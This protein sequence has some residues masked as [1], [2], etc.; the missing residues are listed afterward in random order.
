MTAHLHF[1]RP[2]FTRHPGPGSSRSRRR[3]ALVDFFN[4][5]V[6]VRSGS[7]D[8]YGELCARWWPCTDRRRIE[9][10]RATVAFAVFLLAPAFGLQLGRRSL[11][12]AAAAKV[13]PAP[14]PAAALPALDSAAAAALAPN[15]AAAAP[16]S[17]VDLPNGCQYSVVE[18]GTG[19]P[20]RAGETVAVRLRGLL[21]DGSTFYET[22]NSPLLFKIG[23]AVGAVRADG[24]V[25]PA[26]DVAVSRMRG[27]ERGRLV[28]P[29]DAGYGRGMSIID[30]R[31][32][33]LRALRVPD[34][35]TLRYEIELLRCRDVA[36]V[37]GKAARACCSEASFPCPDPFGA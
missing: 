10:M 6:Q 13:A 16:A 20:P 34:G 15:P 29:S 23:D 24:P 21:M 2:P 8:A 17:I 22:G 12:L 25:T 14:G 1:P 37:D 26:V 5:K 28:A 35:E 11:L 32:A 33:G 27:G 31:R 7:A 18:R 36:A 19:E 4:I 9:A 30:T 3:G